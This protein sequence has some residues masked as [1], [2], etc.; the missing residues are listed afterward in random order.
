MLVALDISDITEI[1]IENAGTYAKILDLPIEF[2]HIENNKSQKQEALTKL[3]ELAK[4]VNEKYGILPEITIKEGNIYTSISD[5]ANQTRPILVMMGTHGLTG[6]QKIFGSKALK[7]IV[8]S[9]IPFWIVQDKPKNVELKNIIFPID[10]TFES[11]EKLTIVKY[12]SHYFKFKVNIVTPNLKDQILRS[13]IKNNLI[14]VDKALTER[15]LE[16]EII[17]GADK[18]DMADA[19]TKVAESINADIIVITTTKHIAWNDY[20]FG[21]PEQRVIP[22][23]AKIPV[24]CVNPRTDLTKFASFR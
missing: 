17:I 20:M 21:A 22:N 24:I 9:S 8:G 16:Y 12:L 10:F 13:K 7:V 6:M 1:V 3:T 19:V 2:L 15:E 4:N 23:A 14:H 18:G 11:K 5:Y